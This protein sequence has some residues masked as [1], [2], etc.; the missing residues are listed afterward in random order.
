[1][2]VFSWKCAK[3]GVEITNCM[4][5]TPEWTQNIV[6]LRPDEEPVM[7][8]YDGYGRI[9]T[10]DGTVDF[11]EEWQEDHAWGEEPTL[12]LSRFYRGEKYTDLP[13]S[14]YGEWQG[15]FLPTNYE[16]LA[17]QLAKACEH[18]MSRGESFKP[19]TFT[20]DCDQLVS[21]TELGPADLVNKPEG[22]YI[23]LASS[24][25]HALDQFHSSVAIKNLEHFQI[26]VKENTECQ[27]NQQPM[28]AS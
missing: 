1:M 9:H 6:W 3:S 8:S 25:E 7:G 21:S 26:T 2:G 10:D 13:P 20:V 19:K 4:I 27:S 14:A 12:V 5:D 28:E 22:E 17:E 16:D 23:Y 11:F 18:K 24:E 15:H